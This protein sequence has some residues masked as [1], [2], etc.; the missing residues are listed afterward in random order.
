LKDYT[1]NNE[2]NKNNKIQ[3][4]IMTRQPSVAGLFYPNKK[5]ELIEMIKKCFLDKKGP[6]ELCQKNKDKKTMAI[7]SPH[8][9]YF[10]SGM[11][12]AN[13]YKEIGE[14]KADTYIILGNSHEGYTTCISTEDWQTPLGI[15]EN[16]K[17]MTEAIIKEGIEEN[18][19]AHYNEHSIEVQIPFLQFIKEKPKIVPIMIGQEENYKETAKKI[20][21]AIKK[22]KKKT[23]IIASSDFTHYGPNYDYIPFTEK[24]KE[25]IQKMDNQ[26]IEIIKKMDADKFT[27]HIQ[28][29][30]STICGAYPIAVCMEIC[31][32]DGV[33]K[34]T[35]LKYYTSGDVVHDYKNAVGY[36][37]IK[38][39]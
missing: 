37:S 32:L 22:T 7:I 8:A 13:G 4:K 31:R 15:A 11:C 30:A 3:N 29:E 26:A 5:E 33:K 25:N 19:E 21:N 34:A 36:A 35:L 6:G 18:N 38:F 17:E 24:V 2:T 9:G 14:T 16:D 12:A 20:F 28:I 10:Y 1:K 27:E 39:E 23:I